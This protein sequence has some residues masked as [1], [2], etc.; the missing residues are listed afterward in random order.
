MLIAA[1][2]RRASCKSSSVQQPPNAGSPSRCPE[3]SYNCIDRPMTSWPS[4]ASSA[5]AT[6]ESTPPDIATTILATSHRCFPRQPAQLVHQ[7]RQERDDAV[8]FLGRR[9]QP[10]TETQR[11]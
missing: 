7:V 3:A 2:T 10:E 8:D 4:S 1:A 5:A 9:E 6:D 11:A